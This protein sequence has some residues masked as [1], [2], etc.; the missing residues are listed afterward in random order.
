MERETRMPDVAIRKATQ[1]ELPDLYRLL[2][3]RASFDGA[4]G[5]LTA[6]EFELGEAVFYE[7]EDAVVL[8]GINLPSATQGA[9]RGC[10]FISTSG[11]ND[12]TIAELGSLGDFVRSVAVLAT[13]VILVFKMRGTPAE[14]ASQTRGEIKNENEMWHQLRQDSKLLGI[15]VR[16]Q[17]DYENLTGS[18]RL[19]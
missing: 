15:H 17:R 5:A 3:A 7:R 11:G 4:S 8:K 6:S 18:D 9:L 13:L 12:M 10:S 2:Q 19:D 14:I 1:S 16:A